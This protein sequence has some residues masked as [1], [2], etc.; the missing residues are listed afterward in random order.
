MNEVH[1]AP[2]GTGNAGRDYNLCPSWGVEDETGVGYKAVKCTVLA[3][4]SFSDFVLNKCSW[5]SSSLWLSS[6]KLILMVFAHLKNR[7]M[8]KQSF[9]FLILTFLHCDDIALC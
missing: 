6:E 3:R 7:C 2:S 1:S 9:P 5:V 4:I 8:E